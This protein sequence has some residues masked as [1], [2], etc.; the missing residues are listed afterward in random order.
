[1]TGDLKIRER[2]LAKHR[3]QVE[4]HKQEELKRQRELQ[5]QRVIWARHAVQRVF[6]IGTGHA[7]V[8][9]PEDWDGEVLRVEG[10]CV[11]IHD[12]K[13][14]NHSRVDVFMAQTED[15]LPEWVEIDS[16]SRLGERLDSGVP[17]DPADCLV[18]FNPDTE[19]SVMVRV[20]QG[21]Y[22]RPDDGEWQE[23]GQ[24]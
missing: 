19:E 11:R 5:A 6:Q 22:A 1:M 21:V 9:I 8:L 20:Q 4:Y 12:A 23:V 2:A 18:L 24:P 13:H 17:A 16:L 7:A 3:H 14:G 10:L 15:A